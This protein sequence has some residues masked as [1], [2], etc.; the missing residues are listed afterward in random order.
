VLPVH[1]SFAQ[2]PCSYSDALKKRLED[3][4][5]RQVTESASTTSDKEVGSEW[6]SKSINVV[7][8]LPLQPEELSDDDTDEQ[9]E[10]EDDD[11][12]GGPPLKRAK[13]SSGSGE[14]NKKKV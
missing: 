14:K 1:A 9:E 2:A 12:D 8:T 6:P 3:E 13:T 4:A 11:S 7:S 10:E 5:K